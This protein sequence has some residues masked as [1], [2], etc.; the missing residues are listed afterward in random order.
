MP[1]MIVS[2]KIDIVTGR[3][4]AGLSTNG[5]DHVITTG[6]TTDYGTYPQ[7]A[8]LDINGVVTAQTAIDVFI[9]NDISIYDALALEVYVISG[10]A[11]ALKAFP[12]YDGVTFSTVGLAITDLSSATLTTAIAGGSGITIV[13]NY[14]IALPA[15]TRKIKLS[16]SASTAGNLSFRGGIWKR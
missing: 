7:N 6:G 2:S 8:Y 1:G 3:E 11:G 14:M 10:T 16:F 5:A 13:G 9:S 15:K 12:S 4:T